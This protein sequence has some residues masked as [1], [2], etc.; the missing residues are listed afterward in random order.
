MQVKFLTVRWN[1][2]FSIVLL[3]VT[4]FFVIAVLAG[5]NVPLAGGGISSFI[6]LVVIGGISCGLSEGQSIMRSVRHKQN[7]G[8]STYLK[9]HPLTIIGEVLGI[10]ALLL[11]IL[12]FYGRNIGFITGYS[13]AFLV[14]AVIIFVLFGLNLRRLSVRIQRF[15]PSQDLRILG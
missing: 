4:V 6:T 15:S 8:K 7:T 13:M 9:R 3:C 11:I 14:L 2:I 12:T 1:N 5:A 10:F